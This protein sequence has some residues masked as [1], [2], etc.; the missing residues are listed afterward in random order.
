MKNQNAEGADIEKLHFNVARLDRGGE[1]FEVVI[2]SDK[3]AAFR[4]GGLDDIAE[5]LKAEHVFSDAKKGMRASE[6]HMNQALPL[7]LHE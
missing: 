7:L 3:A 1:R 4:S 2:D 6:N 5:V